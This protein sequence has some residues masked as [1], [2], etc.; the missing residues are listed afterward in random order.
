MKEL[1]NIPTGGNNQSSTNFHQTCKIGEKT[2]AK[3][4][5]FSNIMQVKQVMQVY[6]ASISLRIHS[7]YGK[8]RTR[9][10]PNTGTFTL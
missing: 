5:S 9:V 3:N 8:M 6:Y 7:E 10:T 4:V 1:H 2:A